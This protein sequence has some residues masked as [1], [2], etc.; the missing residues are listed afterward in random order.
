MYELIQNAEDNNYLLTSLSSKPPWLR[1]VLYQDRV[2]IDSNEDGFSEADIKAI[3]S[4]GE[5]TKTHARG[6]IG[7]K[8]IGFK[9]VFKIAYKVRI[10]SGAFSFAFEHRRNSNDNGL[11]MVTPLN[12]PHRDIP[13]D[14]LTRMTLYLLGTCD[15]DSVCK[16]FLDLPDTLLLFL[17]KL[18]KLSI[19]IVLG[20]GPPHERTYTLTSSGNRAKIHKAPISNSTREYLITRRRVSTMPHD[21]ARQGI[22]DAEIILAFP[23]E[24]NDAPLIEEQHVFAFLPLRKVAYKVGPGPSPIDLV[25][26]VTLLT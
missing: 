10:Q 7:E 6:Y 24:A 14:V 21:G 4:T 1:F 23:L 11:G 13:N 3:C 5:S 16:G 15:R 12:E 18:E 22:T 2:E 20:Q 9:S 19:R 25:T 17:K 26:L 8:G